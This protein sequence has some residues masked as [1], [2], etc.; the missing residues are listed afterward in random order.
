MGSQKDYG[1]QASSY[2]TT[3]LPDTSQLC[4]QDALP[5]GTRSAQCYHRWDSHRIRRKWPSSAVKLLRDVTARGYGHTCPWHLGKISCSKNMVGWV[6]KIFCHVGQTKN[7]LER[8]CLFRHHYPELFITDK[9]LLRVHQ[10]ILY[11]VCISR[12]KHGELPSQTVCNQTNVTLPQSSD[13][14][15]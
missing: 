15:W 14:C 1:H 6:W 8:W 7:L 11:R 10:L 9:S 3:P 12:R 4:S 5:A 2:P 13:R